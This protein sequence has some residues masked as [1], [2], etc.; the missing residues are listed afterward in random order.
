MVSLWA[1]DSERMTGD[2]LNE[3]I[4]GELFPTLKERLNLQGPTGARAVVVR[5][6]F[7]RA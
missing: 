2:A 1:A 6:V 5:S 7:G 3:F 4:N